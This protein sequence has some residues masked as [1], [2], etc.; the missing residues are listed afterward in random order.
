M[1]YNVLRI[2]EVAEGNLGKSFLPVGRQGF[3]FY[4]LLS[5]VAYGIAAPFSY[6]QALHQ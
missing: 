2:K 1:S 4:P 6:S 5:E 3:P